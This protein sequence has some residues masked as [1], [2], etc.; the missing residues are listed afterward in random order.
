MRLEDACGHYTEAEEL[1][2][3]L[4]KL[5]KDQNSIP[6]YRVQEEKC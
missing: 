1:Y 4:R 3:R 6:H 5:D 2:K